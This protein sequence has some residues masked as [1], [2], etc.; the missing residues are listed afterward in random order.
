MSESYLPSLAT[1]CENMAS[2]LEQI[3]EKTRPSQTVYAGPTTLCQYSTT[4]RHNDERSKH[5]ALSKAP[6]FKH[7]K[8]TSN[9][10]VFNLSPTSR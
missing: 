9:I 4:E 5:S 8:T 1:S 2:H 7:S 3:M 6:S 10:F